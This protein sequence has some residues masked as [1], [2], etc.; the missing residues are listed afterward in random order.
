[1]STN[2]RLWRKRPASAAFSCIFVWYFLPAPS[3]IEYQ[4]VP[5]SCSTLSIVVRSVTAMLARFPARQRLDGD[6]E[7]LG[8]SPQRLVT[9]SAVALLDL[10][11]RVAAHLQS[12]CELRWP[13]ALRLA[14]S[15][16]FLAHI[17]GAGFRLGHRASFAKVRVLLRTAL[18]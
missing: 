5:T 17:H 18:Y 16:D 9:R 14:K 12:G 1:M 6:S 7:F 4:P 13:D 2:S 8:N 11:E 15:G 10:V 3:T